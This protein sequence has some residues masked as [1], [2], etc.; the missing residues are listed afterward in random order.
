MQESLISV[1]VP[2]YNV[3]KYLNRCIESIVNQTYKNLEIILVDDGSPDN[4][5]AMC[6]KWAARDK[7][8]KVIHKENGGLSDARNAGMKVATG[9]LMAFVDSDDWIDHN[10][11]QLLH[12]N[13]TMHNSDISACGVEMVWENGTTS[14]LLTKKGKCVLNTKEALKAVID[15]TWLHDPVWYKLYT[16]NLVRDILFPVGKFHEDV[17]WTYQAISKA[18]KISVFDLPCY[19]YLQ[20]NGSIMGEKYSLKRLDALEARIQRI[21]FIENQYPELLR[22]ERIEFCFY[23][24]WSMQKVLRCLKGEERQFGIDIIVNVWKQ[25]GLVE[26]RTMKEKIWLRLSEISLHST[27]KIRNLLRIGL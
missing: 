15:G 12:E 17:F 2:V 8:I 23:C 10:M 11:Y 3:E 9:T 4:C 19:Y 14:K 7:R 27:A 21:L 26:G 6:D 16:T 1:I 22:D 25:I 24:I 5:P 18:N 13:M 20:R